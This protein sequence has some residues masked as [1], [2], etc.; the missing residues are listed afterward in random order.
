M[1]TLVFAFDVSNCDDVDFEMFMK[2]LFDAQKNAPLG[3][4]KYVTFDKHSTLSIHRKLDE[5]RNPE[6]EEIGG[7]S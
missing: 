4:C 1:K 7:D 5:L 3:L 2:R 6:G